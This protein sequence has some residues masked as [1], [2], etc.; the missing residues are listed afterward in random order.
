[1]YSIGYD[2]GSS[3]IKIAITQNDTGKRVIVLQEPQEEME[4]IVPQQGWAEQDPDVWWQ[5]ICTGTQKAIKEARIEAT[6]ITNIGISYQMHGLVIVNEEG[7]SLRNAI[8]WCD[9]RAVAIG[10]EAYESLGHKWCAENLYN[11]PGNFTASKLKWVQENEPN[12][13]NS[14]YKYMLPGD[15]I[16]YKLTGKFTTTKNGLSEGTLWNYKTNELAVELLDYY[17]I[18]QD[19][20]PT[21]VNNFENQGEVHAQGA[22]ESGLPEGATLCYRSGDQPNNA[23]SLNILNPGEVAATGGTSG[24]VYA[25]TAQKTFKEISKV[26]HFAHVN[27]TGT[28]PSV[29]RLLNVNGCGIQY[30]WIKNLCEV[31]TYEE[32]NTL[33]ASIPIGSE[34]LVILPFGNGAERM[35][36]NKTIGTHMAHIDLNKHKTAHICRAALEGI[37]FS[38]VYGIEILKNDGT[39]IQVLRAGNDNLFRSEVFATTVST[40]INQDIEIYDTTGAVGAARASTVQNND[41]SQFAE[42]ITANDFI[43]TYQPREDKTA[44]QNAYKVWKAQ[45]EHTLTLK[46]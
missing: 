31:P 32:M 37:A 6:E 23:L 28:T 44:F 1:M 9:S 35:F 42:H 27:Y 30:R 15:Y 46:Q 10:N 34:G 8:I 24:V 12:I 21:L 25:V 41:F 18:D 33:A 3:S 5:Y 22:R 45:L 14:I 38:L 17:G 36:D 11:A 2:I 7:K 29:G 13:Y 19:L 20:T 26:N 43:K 39:A 40:L 16:A 4:M